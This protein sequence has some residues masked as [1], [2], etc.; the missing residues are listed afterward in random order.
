M[1]IFSSLMFYL[2]HSVKKRFMFVSIHNP[3][4]NY[5]TSKDSTG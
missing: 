5:E 2:S 3:N 4:M 1:F